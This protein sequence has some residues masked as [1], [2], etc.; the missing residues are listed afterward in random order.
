MKV[1]K[2]PWY[3]T[4]QNIFHL[5]SDILGF[6]EKY[7][8]RYNQSFIFQ[9]SKNRKYMVTSD[10]DVIKH[11]L[12]THHKNYRKDY[13]H[14]KLKLALGNGLLTND[15]DSWLRQRRLMHPAFY[16]S[17]LEVFFNS[18]NNQTIQHL[19]SWSEIENVFIDEEMMQLTSK[20]VVETL[21]GS[22]ASNELRSI[23]HYIYTL[24]QYLVNCIRNPIF[25]NWSNYNGEKTKF[26][27]SLK[28]LDAILYKIIQHKKTEKHSNDLVSMLIEARDADTHEGMS[29][30]QL[31][32]ELMTIY[33]AG[34]ETS[35]Y[36]LSWIMYNLCQHKE[37]YKK[38]KQEV[39]SVMSNGNLTLE[40]FKHLIYLKAVIDE[41]LRL[42]PT[43][44]VISRESKETDI[45]NEIEI[46]DKTIL[47]LSVYHLHRN[48]RYWK[49]A[50]EF[51]PERF[52]DKK[53][54][55]FNANA[56]FPFGAGP[57]MCIG[58]NFALME[59]TI[60]LAQLLFHFDFE[61]ATNQ[62]IVI[63]PLV[64]LKP[65]YGIKLNIIK[66]Q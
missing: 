24:Q 51:I 47:L 43:A 58:I 34:H 8:N 42:Y 11:I 50:D 10:A 33:V 38:A 57:R 39:L 3:L 37:A 22:Q 63:E 65:K 18:M 21:L 45:V 2:I 28:E 25:E 48:P 31:R 46:P 12:I 15:G 14:N 13:A 40:N 55:L 16:K 49:H 23:Q 17:R 4:L 64:T 53:D 20:I 26:K 35:G 1:S 44:Y 30:Q 27:H 60:V 32:D 41:T 61:L 19:N 56:Y 54:T 29:D 9:L 52:L 66:N 62:E 5:S 7:L 59:I 36:A 6:F